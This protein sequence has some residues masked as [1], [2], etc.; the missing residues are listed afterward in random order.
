M[1]VTG[2]THKRPGAGPQAVGRSL[3]DGSAGRPL[4]AM[5]VAFQAALFLA[6]TALSLVFLCMGQHLESINYC[7]VGCLFFTA[8]AVIGGRGATK[9]KAKQ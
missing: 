2:A 5:W 7:A 1:S 6:L 4:H 9:R 8:L 3:R